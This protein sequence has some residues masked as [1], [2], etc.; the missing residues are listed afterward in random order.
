M[1]GW[2]V[3]HTI[4]WP[5]ILLTS[6]LSAALPRRFVFGYLEYLVPTV[7]NYDTGVSSCGFT[8]THSL[9]HSKRKEYARRSYLTADLCE[10]TKG[11]SNC[12]LHG[13]PVR[14]PISLPTRRLMLW[15]NAFS[16]L[17]GR[18]FLVEPWSNIQW[19]GCHSIMSVW[20]P[21]QREAACLLSTSKRRGDRAIEQHIR[22]E[23]PTTHRIFFR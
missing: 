12:I 3:Q 19:G 1:S 6:H 17:M 14:V 15:P 13:V 4:S 16:M 22:W 11:L 2:R 21:D 20:R 23:D 18:W 8:L 10:W 9:S 5:S 7:A